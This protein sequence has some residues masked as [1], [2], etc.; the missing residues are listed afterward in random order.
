[1]SGLS[2]E[3]PVDR[4]HCL[5]KVKTECVVLMSKINCRTTSYNFMES[6][7]SEYQRRIIGIAGYF[8]R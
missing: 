5:V 6:E 4:K 3:M 1:M 8:I 2:K 7:R